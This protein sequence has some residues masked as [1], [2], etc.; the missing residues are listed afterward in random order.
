MLATPALVGFDA[1][2]AA[3]VEVAALEPLV[4]V[5]EPFPPPAWLLPSGGER[6]ACPKLT[7]NFSH[8]SPTVPKSAVVLPASKAMV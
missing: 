5:L 8:H 6:V 1:V 3:P 2:P 7:P 4:A